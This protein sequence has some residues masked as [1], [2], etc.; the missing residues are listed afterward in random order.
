MT[1][2]VWSS[3]GDKLKISSSRSDIR[4]ID[5]PQSLTPPNISIFCFLANHSYLRASKSSGVLLNF[6]R[7]NE[8]SGED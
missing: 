1:S 5:K 8:A 7:A 6:A 3:V 2:Y 4:S